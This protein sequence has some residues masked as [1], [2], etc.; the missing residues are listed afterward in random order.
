MILARKPKPL[1]TRDAMGYRGKIGDRSCFFCGTAE[2]FN[3]DGNGSRQMI[4][5]R[6]RDRN[7]FN[8]K[9]GNHVYVCANPNCKQG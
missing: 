7:I 8:V 6:S 9:P 1:D 3:V 5:V 2:E 4:R